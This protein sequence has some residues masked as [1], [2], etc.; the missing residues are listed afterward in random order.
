MILIH[1]ITIDNSH[2]KVDNREE[3]E[4][5]RQAVKKK[6]HSDD[7]LFVIDTDLDLDFEDND[8]RGGAPC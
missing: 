1:R 4:A 7:V 2:I 3:L 8:Q 6:F 5:F